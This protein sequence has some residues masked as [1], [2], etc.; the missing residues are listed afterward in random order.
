MV[1]APV[2]IRCRECGKV[3]RMPTYD[4]QPTYYAKAVGVGVATAIS[5]G[6]LWAILTNIFGGIPFVSSL[7]TL[8]V[9]YRNRPSSLA[10][11]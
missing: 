10:F 1:Q 6:I 3:A 5:G 2:G 9:G 8:G 7:A 4:V 11:L